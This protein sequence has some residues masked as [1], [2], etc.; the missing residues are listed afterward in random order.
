MDD[1]NLASQLID[2]MKKYIHG[3]S[4]ENEREEEQPSEPNTVSEPKPQETKKPIRLPDEESLFEFESFEFDDEPE[5]EDTE[6][7]EAVSDNVDDTYVE[8]EPEAAEVSEEASVPA[9]V[10]DEAEV[11]QTVSEEAE[12]AVIAEDVAPDVEDN[13]EDEMSDVSSDSVSVFFGIPTVAQTEEAVAQTEEAEEETP[14]VEEVVAPLVPSEPEDELEEV[15]EV[16]EVEETEEADEIEEA[17]EPED[18]APRFFNPVGVQEKFDIPGLDAFDDR[19]EKEPEPIVISGLDLDDGED[20]END[21]DD[22]DIDEFFELDDDGIGLAEAQVLD[23]ISET[24]DVS[25]EETAEDEFTEIEDEPDEAMEYNNDVWDDDERA[26]WTERERFTDL[27]ASLP[28]PEMKLGD[29][30]T[31]KNIKNDTKTVKNSGYRYEMTERLPLFPDGLRG[32]KEQDGYIDREKAYCIEREDKRREALAEKL[33]KSSLS[34]IFA[35]ICLG[36]MLV[37]ENVGMFFGGFAT[38]NI[39]LFAGIDILLVLISAF[40]AR[41]SVLDGIRCAVRGIFIPE[42]VTAGVVAFSVLYNVFLML[43]RPLPEEAMLLGIPSGIAVML[44]VLYRYYLLKREI[45]V[46]EVAASYGSYSTEV[47]MYGFRN[48]PEGSELDGYVSPD[49]SLYRINRIS[50][51]DGVYNEQPQRDECYGII[52]ILTLCI[53]CAAV[54]CGIVFGLIGRDLYSGILSAYTVI[55]LASPVSVFVALLVPRYIAATEAAADGGAIIG[56]DEESDEF[57]DNVIML[58][59]SALYPPESLKIVKF[60]VCKSPMLEKHLARA[61]AM[62]KKTGGT[63]SGLFRNMEQSLS[64]QE[65]V[66]VTEVSEHGLTATVDGNTVRAGS[67]SYM[68]KYGITVEKYI[69]VLSADTRVLYISDNGEFFTRIVLSYTPNT[70]LCRKIAGLRHADTVV[71]LKT[72]DPCIDKALVFCTTGLEP[73][74]L[75][76]I[77]FE[78]GDDLAPAETDREGILVSN[79][80]ATGLISALLEYKRQKKLI[81]NGSRFAGVACVAGVALA[82]LLTV[83]NVRL[84]MMSAATL[85]FH[86]ILSG[87]GAFLGTRGTINTKN[88]I[89]K[90]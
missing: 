79:S 17:E 75:R 7:G 88:K 8:N 72:C 71:S 49:S 25:G 53:M 13:E 52:R 63:L 29:G 31:V 37:Y 15:Q 43:C 20:D 51:I 86:A 44:T 34:I 56:F 65:T 84:E 5:D 60:D 87:I 68:E 57:D 54:V 9:E 42:T 33:K 24:P 41:K 77:K 45:K 38:K 21:E 81:F 61:A 32:G 3:N 40:I 39:Y 80:G 28:L 27:C 64:G 78:A 26:S 85:A 48:T 14:E 12:V 30:E 50:R 23:D 58:D 76:V 19:T 82:L 10:F 1:K 74:L 35:A 11:G 6:N 47:R 89:K 70:A 69:G 90:K 59:D 18:D 22:E 4:V 83:F 36:F 66:T 73:E 62:F 67:A 55:A 2:K 46:F 16:E